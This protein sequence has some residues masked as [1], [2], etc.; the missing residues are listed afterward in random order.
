MTNVIINNYKLV[1]QTETLSCLIQ[2]HDEGF[3]YA[4]PCNERDDCP[5]DDQDT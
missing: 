1:M 5:Q 2:V 4:L 3:L